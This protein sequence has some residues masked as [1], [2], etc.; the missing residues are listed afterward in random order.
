MA[1]PTASGFTLAGFY[2]ATRAQRKMEL[3]DCRSPDLSNDRRQNKLCELP[4]TK[5][6]TVLC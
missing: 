1:D 3:N 5:M 2:L 6:M 4:L